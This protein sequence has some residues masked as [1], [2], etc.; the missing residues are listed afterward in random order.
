MIDGGSIKAHLSSSLLYKDGWQEHMFFFNA[1]FM[2]GFDCLIGTGDAI[3]DSN[4]NHL[5]RNLLSSA[6]SEE[7]FHYPESLYLQMDEFQDF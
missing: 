6:S 7:L 2:S 4:R 1:S 5:L 3:F